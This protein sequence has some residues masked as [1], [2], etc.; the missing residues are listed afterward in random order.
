MASTEAPFSL[1]YK[2]ESPEGAEFLITIRP[3]A[4]NAE[5]QLEA[6]Q[7]AERQVKELKDMGFKVVAGYSKGGGSR[8]Y[9]SAG[10]WPKSAPKVTPQGDPDAPKCDCGVNRKFVSGTSKAGKPYK[11]YT[12]INRKCS[13]EWINE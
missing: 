2:M 12:C 10:S 1:T 4:T 13:M 8:P 6:I 7:D 9:G 3:I 5:D 11:G